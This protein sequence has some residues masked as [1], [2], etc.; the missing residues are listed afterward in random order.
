MEG[1]VPLGSQNP[2]R[3]SSGFETTKKREK[4]SHKFFFTIA[5][6]PVGEGAFSGLWKNI[7]GVKGEQTLASFS[8]VNT[9]DKQITNKMRFS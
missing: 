1:N 9:P 2:T 8:T 3:L 7:V 5:Q 6:L 4:K